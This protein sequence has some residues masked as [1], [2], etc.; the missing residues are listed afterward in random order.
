[1][2]IFDSTANQLCWCSSLMQAA[3]D[4]AVEYIHDRKQFGQPIGTFELIQGKVAGKPS[5]H[6]LLIA[7]H[8]KLETRY[9]YQDECIKV[10]CLRCRSG[11]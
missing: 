5:K 7:A 3:F 4:I 10:V 11:M 2:G 6:A 9:V 1:M 8:E